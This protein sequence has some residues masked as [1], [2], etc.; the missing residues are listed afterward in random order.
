MPTIYIDN[1]AYTIEETG[2]SLL[3]VCLTLGFDLP[4]FCW[5]PALHSVG[6][7]RQCAVK[8]FKD[9]KDTR[10]RIVMACE[11]PA[12]DGTRISINDPETVAFRRSITEWM[13]VNHPHDCPV[14]DEGG[15][16][17]LQDMTVMTGHDYRRA[18][19]GQTHL[20]QPGS[21][22]LRQPRDEPLHP[23][24]PLRALLQRFYR[25]PRLRGVRMARPGLL[26][27]SGGWRI[28]E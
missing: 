14:C 23:V 19:F 22:S 28:G 17:H 1:E 7:C 12:K 8:Q 25:W 20:P 4:Y 24:L 27:S 5:H 6:A 3:E 18:R 2:K 21:R 9:E 15:E 26:R 16:C 11:T 10:G 13:M